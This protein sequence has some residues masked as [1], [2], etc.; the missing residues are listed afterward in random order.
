MTLPLEVCI[1]CNLMPLGCCA[2]ASEVCIFLAGGMAEVFF[3]FT[4]GLSSECVK[5]R[6]GEICSA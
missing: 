2:E 6:R 4:G 3:R 5:A 1:N